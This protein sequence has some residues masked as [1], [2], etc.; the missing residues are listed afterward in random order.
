METLDAEIHS[1]RQ[2]INGIEKEM[3]RI[4]ELQLLP[5][6]LWTAGDKVSYGKEQ[7]NDD[8]LCERHNNLEKRVVIIEESLLMLLKTKDRLSVQQ[9][10]QIKR[11]I[12]HQGPIYESNYHVPFESIEMY[13]ELIDQFSREGVISMLYGPR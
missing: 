2:K 6:N 3:A 1:L 11:G 7:R 13:K 12:E 4:K 8:L 5:Y 9:P 10:L